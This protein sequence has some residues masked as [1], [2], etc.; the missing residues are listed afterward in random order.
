M[1]K[2]KKIIQ[3]P[4]EEDLLERIDA[5]A[6]ILAEN[7]ATFIREACQQRVKHLQNKKLDRVYT[8][9]YKKIPEDTKW[10]RSAAKLLA[11]RLA[12]EEW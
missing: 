9:G 12:R 1:D 3:I 5:S 7:R 11:T 10:S 8:R 6:A 2:A 4:I